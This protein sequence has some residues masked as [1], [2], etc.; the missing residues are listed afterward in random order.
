MLISYFF[1]R[2]TRTFTTLLLI[3]VL[4]LPFQSSPL[5]DPI[6]FFVDFFQGCSKDHALS[7]SVEN[8]YP[9]ESSVTQM[10]DI[11]AKVNRRPRTKSRVEREISKEFFWDLFQYT[12]R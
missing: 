7:L 8:P 9:G 2:I 11:F 3:E 5:I 1:V 12:M 10:I 6:L 4:S